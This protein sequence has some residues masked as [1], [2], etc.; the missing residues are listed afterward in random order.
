[1]LPILP[2]EQVLDTEVLSLLETI[3]KILA[4]FNQPTSYTSNQN[5]F[6]ESFM[7]EVDNQTTQYLNDR[8]IQ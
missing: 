5:T 4:E 3:D 2:E 7:Q 1:V 6:L 8:F